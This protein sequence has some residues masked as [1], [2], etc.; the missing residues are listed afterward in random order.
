SLDEEKFAELINVD[1]ETA[2]KIMRSPTNKLSFKI[3]KTISE[4][5]NIPLH[6]RYT[7]HWKELSKEELLRLIDWVDQ[8]KVEKSDEITKVILPLRKEKRLLELLGVPHTLSTE[9]VVIQGDDSAAFLY[10]LSITNSLD[11]IK[12]RKAIQESKIEDVL[13]ILKS[14]SKIPLRDKS[15]IFIGARMGRPEKAKMRK[16]TGS[17]HSLFPCGNEGGRLRSFNS[18]LEN[19]KITAEFPIFYCDNCKRKTIY[20]RCHICDKKTKPKY[21]CRDCGELEKECSHGPNKYVR[22]TL[23]IREYF[24][25]ALKMLGEKHYP[26]LIKGVRGTS[27]KDHIPEH[28][29][30]G[31][32]RAKHNICV[33]KD[34]TTRYDMTEL[35]ITHFKPKEIGTDIETLKKLGYETDIHGKIL[36]NEN[37]I[38]EIKPQD[39][40]LPASPDSPD[41]KAS[42]VLLRVA[43]F[44]D[45]LL[46]RLY[47]L[48]PFYKASKKEDLIGH[49]VIGLAPHIS[50][51]IV[52]RII[53]FSETQTCLGHPLWHAAHRRDC[54][55]DENC[56]MLLME[57]LLNFS[58]Q[59]LPDRRGGRTMDAPLVLTYV[60]NPSEVDDMVHKVDV[61]SRYPLEFYEACRQYK[62]PWEVKIDKVGDRLGTE[63]QYESMGFTHDTEDFNEGVRCSSYK[64]LP[65]MEEKLKKQMQ[66]AEKIRAVDQEDVAR[67]VIEKHLIKDVRGNLRKFSM[68]KFRCST[69]NES[70]RRPP[71]MGKCLK[72]N[73]KII[74]TISEGSIIKYLEPSISLAKKYTNSNYLAQV[75]E[76]TRRRIESVFGR[77]KEKQT[78]LKAWFS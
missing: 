34:G 23:P 73:G 62:Q 3:A 17:P 53:G 74:F 32:L 76:I 66:T 50:A 26:D 8:S 36:E 4:S 11:I 35:P 22:Q 63:K 19:Q 39:A 59:Y 5:F 20:S 9:Y 47:K 7:Y 44:V 52:G 65:T 18:A 16:L 58:R 14:L 10:N 68:Q 6:P 41:E 15:G 24:D 25:S 33:N 13:E 29:A 61:V 67:L 28:L 51:G 31:I 75:L 37:Q 1:L 40:I 43:N 49:L 45:D 60:L 27:N 56:V 30:K 2:R 38:L 54:D 70:Y 42:D 64:T 77:Q 78:G 21:N 71:L 55:G 57:A 48:K 46:V 72:C 69:C 12:I